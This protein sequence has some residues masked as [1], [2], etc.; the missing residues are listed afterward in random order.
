MKGRLKEDVAGDLVDFVGTN[1][2]QFMDY[3]KNHLGYEDS[4][5]R[6]KEIEKALHKC[7]D[8]IYSDE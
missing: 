1:W 2:Y 5:Q 6:A 8:M 3:L 7:A 4:E